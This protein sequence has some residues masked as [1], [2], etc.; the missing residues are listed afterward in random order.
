[1]GFLCS[2]TVKSRIGVQSPN[3]MYLMHL[4]KLHIICHV[5]TSGSMKT[6]NSTVN[7]F[8]LNQQI[9]FGAWTAAEWIVMPSS[10]YKLQ[11]LVL[12]P[13]A[14][15]SESPSLMWQTEARFHEQNARSTADMQG[16]TKLYQLRHSVVSL[17]FEEVKLW[18]AQNNFNFKVNS[19]HQKFGHLFS[20]VTEN[21][22]R[23]DNRQHMSEETAACRRSWKNGRKSFLPETR[24][25]LI[26]R[27]RK[28]VSGVNKKKTSESIPKHFT[29]ES[30]SVSDTC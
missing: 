2:A 29:K 17:S 5:G 1:M 10:Q 26:S 16:C 14:D 7:Q 18:A 22:C 11:T 19:D 3:W 28:K 15:V 30:P 21:Q 27:A 24:G 25:Q 23:S 9:G 6:E 12:M 8:N 20:I 4:R 13:L